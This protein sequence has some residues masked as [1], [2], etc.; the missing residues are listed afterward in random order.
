MGVLIT[1][2]DA[3]A[4]PL[5]VILAVAITII[6]ALLVLLMALQLPNLW[7]D[8]TVPDIFQITKIGGINPYGN[9]DENYVVVMNTGDTAYDNRNVSAKVYRNGDHLPDIPY[10]NEH[11]FLPVKP[12]GIRLTGG[13]GTDNYL[14]NPNARIYIDFSQGT[15]H[16]RDTVQFDVYD[17]TTNQL[18]S[19]DTYPHANA[20][21]ER[22]MRLYFNHQD[23]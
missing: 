6:L 23:A 10:I 22:C 11:K 20:I 15:L 18:I 3:A 9:F 8:P 14:W 17:R 13:A 19:R 5:G 7:Y 1:N 12:N 21:Q 16:P 2:N 4:S